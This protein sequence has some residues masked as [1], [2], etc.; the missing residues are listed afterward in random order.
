MTQ[1]ATPVGG[2]GN[3]A[4]ADPAD[5]FNDIADEM[6]G[7][8]PERNNRQKSPKKKAPEPDAE[9]EEA[10]DEE[11]I[12]PEEELPAID[13]PNS[14]TAEEKETFKSLPREA[15]EFTARRIGE[16]EKGFQ[17]KAQEA[18]QIKQTAQLEALKVV[19][20]IK[21]EAAERLQSYAKQFEVKAPDAV[22]MDP[23]SQY[24]NPAAYAQQL[25]HYQHSTAQ[26][27]QAQRDAETARS[28]QA[29]IQAARAEH[30]AQA[31][32]QQLEAELP[33]LLDP[34]NGQTLARELNATAELLGFDPNEISDVS[35]IK[36]LKQT[37]EWKS[38]S[39]KYRKLMARKMERVRAGKAPPPISKPGTAREPEQTRRVK[40]DQ[41][42]Q[43]ALTAKGR[44]QRD[45]ALAVWAEQSGFLD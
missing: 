38:D 42:W 10:A 11:D 29:Q 26:R 8:E 15:Q 34:E 16:L 39:D 13:P 7:V 44:P 22:L 35:A 20:Q 9:A 1:E 30:E 4:D 5:A 37:A 21:A 33:E 41:A 6:L 43:V 3:P 31:F 12:E 2:D 40:A 14:L 36:A 45:D 23:Q 19:E 24:Y 18:A 27:E 32:R 17:S 25:Q 28:E